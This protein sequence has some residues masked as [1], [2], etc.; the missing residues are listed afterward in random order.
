MSIKNTSKE[1]KKVTREQKI[2]VKNSF[3]SFMHHYGNFFFS[4]ITAVIIARVISME[5]WGFL[6]LALSLIGFFT[7]ILAF[8][9]PSLGLSLIYY[10]S[11]F[12]ALNQNTKLRSF[13]RTAMILRV[14]FVIP[15]FFL[16]ILIFTIFVE[17]F[18]INLKENFYLFYL[19][20]PLII[21][22]GLGS[23]LADL[24]RALNMFNINLFLLIIKNVIYIGGL[25]YFFF[26]IESIKVSYIAVIIL[27][28]SVIPFIINCFIIFLKFQFSIKKS[29]EE[30]ESFK[31]CVK[32]IY[33]YG[34]YL[35]ITDALSAF[36]VEIK[37][38]LVGIYEITDMVT[39]YHIAKRYNSVSGSA[40]TP[41][42]RPLS[43]SLT[44]LY[45]KDQFHQIQKLFNRIINYS[46]LLFLLVTGFLFFIADFFLYLIYGEP[47]LIFSLL[48]KLSLISIIFNILDSFLGSFLLASNKVKILSVVALVFGPL[49]LAFFAFGLIFFGIIGGVV[50]SMIANMITLISYTII[51]HKFNL[52]LDVKKLILL[53]SIFFISLFSALI[54]ETLMLK[55]IYLSILKNLNLLIF[56]Y[57]NPLSF[58]VFL[59]SFIILNITFKF[60]IIS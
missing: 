50:F 39:G 4:L 13:V 36:S 34:S 15:I 18:K 16:S 37:T 31:E 11:R 8:L 55:H 51:L 21:I 33:K 25:L 49:Q 41:L 59:F 57:F 58:V 24:T 43:I 22:N 44:K 56:Q 47:Y 42:N 32:N 14:L 45:S 1:K 54:L 17:F 7:I 30:G 5:E 48:V 6:I 20:V 40:I 52:K 27:F 35:S 53:F 28:S 38:Q 19:L 2:L 9:P 3:Y 12:K 60:I 10:V 29:E 23:I 46:L 26:Y